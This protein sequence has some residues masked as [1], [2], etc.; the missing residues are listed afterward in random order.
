MEK[1]RIQ[2]SQTEV[3]V[4]LRSGP[5]YLRRIGSWLDSY[6]ERLRFETLLTCITDRA[7]E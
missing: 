6:Q 1:R 7:S 2:H 3:G 5:R 4:W